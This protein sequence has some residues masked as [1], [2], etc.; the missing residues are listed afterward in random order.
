M[1]DEATL[2]GTLALD[3]LVSAAGQAGSKVL[4]LGD[5]A[6]IGS[7]EAG[8]AFSLLVR[9]RGDLVAELTD[10]RRFRSEWENAASLELRRGDR[11]AIDAYEAHDR[12]TGGDR[13]SCS[14][15]STRPG[16]PTLTPASRA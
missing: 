12:I 9:D 8:G 13:E 6:Q 10:V 14:T 5:G 3:E 7:V 1:I 11:S 16:R 15:P 4:L 2:A